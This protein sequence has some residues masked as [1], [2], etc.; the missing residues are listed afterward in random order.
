MKHGILSL[1]VGIFALMLCDA[2]VADVVFSSF[3]GT[4][5]AIG[6]IAGA[7]SSFK[8]TGSRINDLSGTSFALGYSDGERLLVAQRG[9][10]MDDRVSIYDPS[11]LASPIIKEATWENARGVCGV[12]LIGGYIYVMGSSGANIVKVSASDYSKI[13]EYRFTDALPGYTSYGASLA[14]YN[15]ELFALF[16]EANSSSNYADSTLVRL[17][18]KLE[19]LGTL[20]LP[21]NA[22]TVVRSGNNLYVASFGGAELELVRGSESKLDRITV[23]ASNMYQTTLVKSSVLDGQNSQIAAVA[24]APDG[25]AMLATHAVS[26]SNSV[27]ARLHILDS[28]LNPSSKITLSRTFAG[29]YTYIAYDETNGY[30]WVSNNNSGAGVSVRDQIAAFSPSNGAEIVS[31]NNNDIDGYSN[32]ITVVKKTASGGGDGGDSSDKDKLAGGC[33]T[34]EAGSAMAMFVAFF[35]SAA[36]LLVR[37]SGAAR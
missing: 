22:H 4:S 14:Q 24:F 15:G 30:F 18:D 37:R 33:S 19:A 27:T 7:G 5:G 9:A 13:D 23:E 1:F 32:Y 36:T 8:V 31:F 26:G 35:A 16:T 2:A 6:V 11:D 34:G 29:F 28:S 20:K 3:K 17:N 10:N 12:E 25:T 21:K